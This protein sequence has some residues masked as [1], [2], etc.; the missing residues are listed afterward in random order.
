MYT[1]SVTFSAA[2]LGASGTFLQAWLSLRE[3]GRQRRNDVDTL[4]ARDDLRRDVRLLRHPL[5]WRRWRAEVNDAVTLEERRRL[6]ELEWQLAAW[7]LIT[8][9]VLLG[10]VASLR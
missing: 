4:R 10:V 3:L 1:A 5:R 2:V 9:G 7:S 8:T 6:R